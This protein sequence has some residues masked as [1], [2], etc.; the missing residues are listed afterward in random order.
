MCKNVSQQQ[1]H[2][3][4]QQKTIA[5]A[6]LYNNDNSVILPPPWIG[7]HIVVPVKQIDYIYI[8]I[9]TNY[10]GKLY[11]HV[12]E[13]A[14]QRII[15][16]LPPMVRMHDGTRAVAP[17]HGLKFKVQL[18]W[19]STP[20]S[21]SPPTEKKKKRI[22]SGGSSETKRLQWVDAWSVVPAPVA[23]YITIWCACIQRRSQ[24]KAAGGAR[25]RTPTAS[26]QEKLLRYNNTPWVSIFKKPTA[27][28]TQLY[29]T[30]GTS[31]CTSAAFFVA[32]RWELVPLSIVQLSVSLSLSRLLPR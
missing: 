24:T 9:V 5:T 17:S 26:L 11:I 27:V 6:V 13:Y 23:S 12:M 31:T 32:E 14:A 7:V 2:N 10:T 16:K 15:T 25:Q 18:L 30:R 4:T 1:Q 22:F 28:Y 21:V 29:D 19:R 8:L 3:T 20:R